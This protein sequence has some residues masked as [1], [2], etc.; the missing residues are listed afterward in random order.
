MQS[1]MRNLG[2]PWLVACII[3]LAFFASLDAVRAVDKSESCLPIRDGDDLQ[4]PDTAAQTDIGLVQIAGPLEDPWAIAF[5]PGGEILVTERAGRLRIIENGHLREEPISGTPAVI[6][7]SHA[8]LMDVTLAPDFATSRTLYLTY[9]GGDEKRAVIRIM[10]AKLQDR[11]LVE[12]VNV[13]ETRPA[14]SGLEQLGARLAFG[15]D[16]MLYLTV[17]ERSQRER[18]QDLMDHSGSILRLRPDGTV[19][20]DNPFVGRSDVLPEIFSFGHRNPQGLVTFAG[21]LWSVEH[22]EKGG[23]ELNV[24]EAGKNYGWPIVTYGTGYDDT[25]IGIG[26]EAPGMT[27]PVHYWVP[28]IAPSSLAVYEGDVM[29]PEWRGNL[30]VGALAGQMLVRMVVVDGVVQREERLFVEEI[31]RI[32]DVGVSPD[33]YIYVLGDGPEAALYR[34]EPM[35]EVTLNPDRGRGNGNSPRRSLR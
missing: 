35:E 14:V 10:R 9:V 30:L 17:G 24:I 34:L 5:L 11:Q 26:T 8:G 28:S 6:R 25:P 13:F 18:A 19:P 22:G 23:D 2:R 31:G 4:C 21:K 20:P 16:G 12:Q 33:G 32:R 29:P 15:P 7:E 27:S 3:Q 1:F